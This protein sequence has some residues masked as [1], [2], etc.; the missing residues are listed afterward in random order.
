MSLS[1][2]A[3]LLAPLSSV[4]IA[5]L[6]PSMV[7]RQATQQPQGTGTATVVSPQEP[8]PLA[9]GA[10][11][12]PSFD[13]APLL[14]ETQRIALTPN[15]DGVIGEE[16][17]DPLTVDGETA[18][19]F[20]WEPTALHFAAKIPVGS[21]LL[22]S[23]DFGSNGWLIGKDNLELRFH[24]DASGSVSVTGRILDGTGING[25]VWVPVPGFAVSSLAVAKVDGTTLTL[26]A[27]VRDPGEGLLSLVEGKS[28]SI[29][30]DA[31]PNAGVEMAAYLP[32]VLA[33]VRLGYYRSAGLPA[34]L[35][36]RPE[37]ASRSVVPGQ[38]LGMRLT[39]EGKNELGVSRV[40]MRAE[41]TARSI[42][43]LLEVPFPGFDRKG[44]AFVDYQTAIAPTPDLGFRILRGTVQTRDGVPGITQTSFRVGPLVDV[45][46]VREEL[47]AKDSDRS[48]KISFYLRSNSGRGTAGSVK[49]SVPEPLRILNGS[50]RRF[51]IARGRGGSRQ[52]FEIYIP[53][54][55]TGTFPVTFDMVVNK[56]PST[57]KGFITI[58]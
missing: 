27:T 57:Q 50:D 44:R 35:V 46:L 21:D 39:F 26:E 10:L 23:L 49:V 13:K 40:D 36:F 3:F 42:A 14:V 8:Q 16:E 17:W 6:Y 15:L 7:A 19:F 22:V 38:A 12:A 32:R 11:T 56:E 41:G 31:A 34:G 54:G 24:P 37:G 9:R 20:E 45:D 51:E 1:L 29:R 2:V 5:P 33:A 58:H 53:K 55:T 4:G 25:P 48:Q 18:T 47:S 28:I 43:N 30:A 52:V